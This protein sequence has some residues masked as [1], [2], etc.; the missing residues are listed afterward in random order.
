MSNI[1]FRLSPALAIVAFC[2][3]GALAQDQG[4]DC[5]LCAKEV[6][7]NADTATCFLQEYEKLAEGD[8]KAVAVDLSDCNSRSVVEP[9]PAPKLGEREPD[10]T[11]IVTRAQLSCL[12]AK[13]EQ[14][15]LVLDP[16]ATIELDACQ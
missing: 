5:G 7:V 15:D 9:L 16:S 13:L 11:F 10:T 4:E 14:P 3:A 2:A 1:I 12:K 6:T 8:S